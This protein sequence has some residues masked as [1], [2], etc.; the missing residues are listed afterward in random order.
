MK[1]LKRIIAILLSAILFV[2]NTVSLQENV[3]SAEDNTAYG[4]SNPET[5]NTGTQIYCEDV[6]AAPGSEIK[7]PVKIGG[8]KGIMGFGIN[9]KFDKN[10]LEPVSVTGG[11][12]L[13]GTFDNNIG[14]NGD[15]DFD[16]LWSGTDAFSED[17]TIFE[18]VF[19]VSEYAQNG[20]TEIIISYSQDDTFN[21]KYGDVEL[22]CID[23]NLFI[24][25]EAKATPIPTAAPTNTPG[26]STGGVCTVYSDDVVYDNEEVLSVPVKLKNNTGLMGFMIHVKYNADLF[27]PAAVDKGEAIPD[28]TTFDDNCGLAADG[29]FI[30]L[31]AGIDEIKTNGCLF[32]LNF[33][34]KEKTG[35]NN[36]VIELSYRQADTFDGNYEDVVLDCRPIKISAS[37]E[38]IDTDKPDETQRPNQ[39]ENPGTTD[40]PNK[41]EEPEATEKPN[42]TENP[43]TTDKPNQTE[44]PGETDEPSRTE[45]PGETDRPNQTENPETTDRP[46]RTENPDVTDKP[47]QTENPGTTDR[48]NRTENP[49]VTDKPNQTENPGT[50]DKPNQTE[51]PGE[52]NKPSRTEE[53][54]GNDLPNINQPPVTQ[55]P[56]PVQTPVI[57]PP[58]GTTDAPG[59]DSSKPA[60]VKIS[61]VKYKSNKSIEVI[62]KKQKNIEG[63]QLQYSLSK[64][65]KPTKMKILSAS[66][67]KVFLKKLKS[68]KSYYIRIRSYRFYRGKKLYGGWSKVKRCK[69]K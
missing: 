67:V 42:Q 60:K 7:V 37:E 53:P 34:V 25:G 32:T 62:W 61:K 59:A 1:K 21:E 31:W 5:E 30:I 29:T 33:K 23:V 6:T 2:T 19:K 4:I 41:T 3:A 28:G 52:T 57:A 16:V 10:I 46:N 66:K 43:G 18:M 36:S 22:D 51:K 68:G 40:K 50:T 58:S 20:I 39:T 11:E 13:N 49:D 17:G 14:I 47:N 38:P 15:T 8:N 65:F 63:Y 44:N 55:P 24:E 26:E 12:L 35:L 9:V 45:R 48:P 64:K 56:I 27:E 69:V 54:G